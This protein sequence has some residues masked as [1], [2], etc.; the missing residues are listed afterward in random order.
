MANIF[1]IKRRA[2]GGAAGAPSTLAAAE[3]AFNEQDN[4][5]YYGRGNSG[6]NAVT[7]IPIAGDAKQP[8]DATLTALAGL[9]ATAG[10]VEQT[11]AD[12]FTKRLI[13]TANATDIPTRADGDT[14]Y[15]LAAAGGL[16]L[17]SATAISAASNI[18][19]NEASGLNNTYE[20][21]I[22]ELIDVLVSSNNASLNVQFSSD[23]STFNATNYIYNNQYSDSS[24]TT[25]TVISSNTGSATSISLGAQLS[26]T[27]NK[28]SNFTIEIPNPAQARDPT[29]FTKGHGFNGSGNLFQ[30]SGAGSRVGWSVALKGIQI[31]LTA[32]TITCKAKL[33]GQRKTV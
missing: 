13:G 22:L 29:I 11:G 26:N 19:Y 18:T 17:I 30:F 14:R 4:I 20:K 25:L 5:L 31:T 24:G 1:R 10:L 8:I 28:Y 21:Y 12:A 7:I 16:V 6:G 9:N 33:Y 15:A 27:A 32:G 3:I 2:A 23:G